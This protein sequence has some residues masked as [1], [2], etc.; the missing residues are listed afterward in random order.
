MTVP[1]LYFSTHGPHLGP[2]LV[3][4]L[5]ICSLCRHLRHH[6]FPASQS[7][8][9]FS[10]LSTVKV[11]VCVYC[12]QDARM[13]WDELGLS[14]ASSSALWTLLSLGAFSFLLLISK[15]E[16]LNF[17]FLKALQIKG[18]MH[19][20]SHG[21]AWAGNWMWDCYLGALPPSKTLKV[22]LGGIWCSQHWF[23]NCPYIF[24]SL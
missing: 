20:E 19:V 13:L 3:F 8:Q 9:P 2:L 23:Y 15:M 14:S 16:M 24:T 4:L 5:P 1:P 6:L 17:C 22:F 7:L 10:L 12:R 18:C 11:T 21:C